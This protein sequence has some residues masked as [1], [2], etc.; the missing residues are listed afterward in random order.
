M[1]IVVLLLRSQIME[2]DALIA[3]CSLFGYGSSNIKKKEEILHHCIL[4]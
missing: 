1:T 4:P 2:A 3:L